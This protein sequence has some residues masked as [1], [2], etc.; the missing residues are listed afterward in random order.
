MKVS[1]SANSNFF[2]FS[3]PSTISKR[4]ALCMA[5]ASVSGTGVSS[6]SDSAGASL[7]AP[8]SDDHARGVRQ[9]DKI[10][11]RFVIA[12]LRCTFNAFKHTSMGSIDFS[13]SERH[14]PREWEVN[15]AGVALCT[16]GYPRVRPSINTGSATLTVAV[17]TVLTALS[18][19]CCQVPVRRAGSSP[20]AVR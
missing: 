19:S 9:C 20:T 11:T 1:C 6:N 18:P 5:E 10:A 17:A 3:G 13:A 14:G 16:H 8:A 7:L 12:R 15:A 4:T 2:P